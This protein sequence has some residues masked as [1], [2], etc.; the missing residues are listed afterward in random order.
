MNRAKARSSVC[1][2]LLRFSACSGSANR[3]WATE[4]QLVAF[5]GLLQPAKV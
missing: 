5:S 1:E 2:R 4:T 3:L